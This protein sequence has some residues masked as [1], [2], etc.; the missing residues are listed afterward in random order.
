MIAPTRIGIIG[1]GVIS[2]AYLRGAAA[3][4]WLEVKA[5][6]DINPQVAVAQAE[7]FGVTAMSVED[8]LAD[9]EIGIVVNLT[10]PAAHAEVGGRI[11]DARKHLYTEKPL[12]ADIGSAKRLLSQAGQ[13]GL[14]VGCAP[15]TFLGG[16]HQTA[17][18]A[19][20]A[21]RIGK[22]LGGSMAVLSRGM[23][24]WHP[25][26]DFFFRPGGGPVLDLGPYY[27]TQMVNLLGPVASVS[28]AASMG[29]AT[30]TIGSGPRMGEEVRVEVPTSVSAL[31]TLASGARL[32]F[33]ASW[34]VW[35]H[36][37]SPI[38]Y[39]GTE[40][41][42][43]VP[44]PNFF[45]DAVRISTR[46][47]EWEALAPDDYAFAV[48]N[49]TLRSGRMVADYRAIGLADMAAA[50]AQGRPHRASAELAFHVLDVLAAIAEAAERHCELPVH[51]RCE[52][53]A[54][55]PKG[56]DETVFASSSSLQDH[57]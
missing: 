4:P 20:D 41:S 35:K 46:D 19:L 33:D 9:P 57:N 13:L 38:E 7:A 52:R 24:A 25:N 56:Q 30:R 37:R 29:Y 42:M 3:S 14:R 28:A 1:C 5:V 27:I 50:L 21:G 17:R 2:S 48:P 53:P 12:T 23:E 26:P 32:S 34:D 45:G 18:A 22:V 44:D 31:L 40:G 16:A 8:L 39:Y 15:D 6:A 54:P 55:L 11:L 36:G 10:I 49:R 47:G 51:S 43:Q